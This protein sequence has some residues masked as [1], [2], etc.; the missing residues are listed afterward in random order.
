MRSGAGGS[1]SAASSSMGGRGMGA[2]KG[3]FLQF[4]GKSSR[5]LDPSG[6]PP[7]FP[8]R[9]GGAS[10]FGLGKSSSVDRTST[11][12]SRAALRSAAWRARARLQAWKRAGTL[13]T[14][15]S[16]REPLGWVRRGLLDVDQADLSAFRRQAPVTRASSIVSCAMCLLLGQ[17]PSWQYTSDMLQEPEI[18]D[19]FVHMEVSDVKVRDLA[20]AR[21]LLVHQSMQEGGGFS[22]EGAAMQ[23]KRRFTLRFYNWLLV[24]S[25]PNPGMPAHGIGLE[26]AVDDTEVRAVLE[27]AALTSN[28][29]QTDA[30]RLRT[31]TRRTLADEAELDQEHTRLA[32]ASRPRRASLLDTVA[33]QNRARNKRGSLVVQVMTMDEQDSEAT[34][35]RHGG[36]SKS[37]D[38][39]AA[40]KPVPPPRFG[41]V[42]APRR[43]DFRKGALAPPMMVE[44]SEEEK[45]D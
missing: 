43:P 6:P 32:P 14:L 41:G 42:A 24:L 31:M 4:S 35:P 22:L 17:K 33:I 10:L 44:I 30:K 34:S 9:V 3:S 7:K 40:R 28:T 2:K 16:H 13:Q 15:L 20:L 27:D 45:E 12:A 18:V 25:D 26:G 11:I 21:A 23:S 39:P 38:A 37:G 29:A 36:E 1:S 8:H 5:V 19:F